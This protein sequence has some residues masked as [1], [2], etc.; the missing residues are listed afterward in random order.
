MLNLLELLDNNIKLDAFIGLTGLIV[1]IVV[2]IAEI[3]TSET[4]ELK[5][6]VILYVSKPISRFI[7]VISTLFLIIIASSFSSDINF[8]ATYYIMQAIIDLAII[9]SFISTIRMLHSSIKMVSSNSYSNDKLLSYLKERVQK[10]EEEI[11][12]KYTKFSNNRIETSCRELPNIAFSDYYSIRNLDSYLEV[13][14]NSK[15]HIESF[16]YKK[17]KELSGNLTEKMGLTEKDEPIVIFTRDVGDPVDTTTAI[18]FIK[19]EARN[20]IQFI[21]KIISI[22]TDITNWLIELGSI[23]S[24][25]IKYSEVYDYADYERGN[26][27]YQYL[28][29]LY[30]NDFNKTLDIFMEAISKHYRNKIDIKDNDSFIRALSWIVYISAKYKRT[31]DY[32]RTADMVKQ[33][34]LSKAKYNN[35]DYSEIACEY[36][37][38]FFLAHMLGDVRKKEPEHFAILLADIL[39]IAVECIKNNQPKAIMVLLK[40]AHFD[41]RYFRQNTNDP[42]EYIYYQFIIGLTHALVLKYRNSKQELDE[43]IKASISKIYEWFGNHFITFDSINDFTDKFK[44]Y[45]YYS[46][47]IQEYYHWLDLDF[48]KSKYSYSSSATGIDE[49]IILVICLALLDIDYCNE[50]SDLDFIN[51]NDAFYYNSAADICSQ[52]SEMPLSSINKSYDFDGL[53]KAF[54][55]FAQTAENKQKNYVIDSKIEADSIINL[56]N[57]IKSFVDQDAHLIEQLCEYSKKEYSAIPIKPIGI[58]DI[59]ISKTIL[60]NE[61]SGIDEIAKYVAS[62]IINRLGRIYA[63]QILNHADA[64]SVD[65]ISTPDEYVIFTDEN[66]SAKSELCVITTDYIEEHVLIKKSDLPIITLY[67]ENGQHLKTL[68]D[69]IIIDFIDYSQVKNQ[70]L[71]EDVYPIDMD[72]EEKEAL[73]QQCALKITINAIM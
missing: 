35:N 51:M 26:L 58:L 65:D 34:Y 24:D 70:L 23:N 52:T 22:D 5:K 14:P 17:L 48:S 4:N 30:N 73:L 8:P 6:R 44:Q 11:N 9:V 2:F 15:G 47:P 60:L 54:L 64:T 39:Y 18:C 66:L 28:E 43:D 57:S 1:A 32:V 7:I 50:S 63:D 41:N 19:K 69:L 55:Y 49:K 42:H 33:L 72:N 59:N 31:A 13:F 20:Y 38:R 67:S 29:F 61:I 36:I 45:Y 53:R 12:K 71:N 16:S 27:M 21:N 56:K 3:L 37:N 46:S 68:S 10:D 25:L 40:E 62:M